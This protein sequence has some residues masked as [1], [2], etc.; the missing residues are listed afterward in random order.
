MLNL[1]E[2][3]LCK[4]FTKSWLASADAKR[5]LKR[6]HLEKHCNLISEVVSLFGA[7]NISEDL[8]EY[9][10]ALEKTLIAS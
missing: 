3:R 2:I 4:L 9:Q 8:R 6:A 5:L 1:T 10:R 7:E